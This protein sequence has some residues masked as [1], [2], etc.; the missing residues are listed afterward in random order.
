MLPRGPVWHRPMKILTV[1]VRYGTEQYPTAEEDIAAL[2][3]RQLP[4][5]ER[6]LLVV[7]NALPAGTVT[8]STGRT[9]LGGNNRVREFTAFDRGVEF[10][11]DVLE[12]YDFVHLATSAF[13]TLY[14]GYLERF[15]RPVLD[16]ALA[17][18]ICLGHIDC[19]NEPIRLDAFVSQHWIRTGFFFLTPPVVRAL[20]SFV[21]I[22]DGREFFSGDP[23]RPFRADAPLSDRYQRYIVDWLTGGDVGQGVTWHSRL[24]LTAEGLAAFE[25]KTLC[26]LNEQMLGIRLRAQ[27]CPLVDVTWLARRVAEHSTEAGL[28]HTPWRQQLAGR[29]RDAITV[30]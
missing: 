2:F 19:Y 29:D 8:R 28:W 20:G 25:Q 4:G 30:G 10:A 1:L 11:G 5:V 17:Q 15:S 12:S 13:N 18:P 24:S 23:S 14:T 7:D 21:S 6:D 3:T 9:L 26:I 16:A 22:A 27:G